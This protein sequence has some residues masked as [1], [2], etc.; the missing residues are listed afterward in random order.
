MNPFPESYRLYYHNN[1]KV[2]KNYN[3][4]FYD[5]YCKKYTQHCHELTN[6]VL[7]EKSYQDTCETDN[8]RDRGVFI[9][10][11]IMFWL[12]NRYP[13]V[14]TEITTTIPPDEKNVLVINWLT[15][16]NLS[17]QDRDMIFGL[18]KGHVFVDD[19]FEVHPTR[20]YVMEMLLKDMGYNLDKVTFWTNCPTPDNRFEKSIIR[21][22]WLHL[23]EYGRMLN[24]ETR[25]KIP[26]FNDE[27][28]LNYENKKYKV[29]SLNG[30]ST[31][32]REYILSLA[33]KEGLVN[34]ANNSKEIRYSFLDPW[35]RLP[36]K[37]WFDFPNRNE[38]IPRQLPDDA[39][40]LWIRDR[41]SNPTWWEESFFNL[42]VETNLNWIT[43]NVRLITEKWMKSILYLT[44][45]FNIGD[46]A[47]LE[48][49]H[50][51]LGFN[52]Y[53]NHID[54]RYDSI[55]DFETRCKTMIQTIKDTPMPDKKQWKMMNRIAL[56]NRDHFYNFYIPE[57]EKTFISTLLKK[58]YK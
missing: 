21:H 49:Y 31:F 48:E 4:S 32:P 50:K 44:P 57:L 26:V 24:S 29:L 30:H 12:E 36:S 15:L 18:Y 11:T 38:W 54:R 19:T 45:A 43:P 42:N 39:K 20:T 35:E 37:C 53:E 9:K 47:G 8:A 16:F 22:N 5:S 55:E 28:L 51:Y 7:N 2:N 58:T 1:Q 56:Q 6:H 10:P 27:G 40:E 13:E 46:Y 23:Q 17:D 41:T 25:F 14:T 52:N 34:K 3:Y 33:V